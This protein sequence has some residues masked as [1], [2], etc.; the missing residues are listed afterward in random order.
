MQIGVSLG[1]S[2]ASEVTNAWQTP[3]V[4]S[5]GLKLHST[6]AHTSV[7]GLSLEHGNG[8]RDA[9]ALGAD[10][11]MAE[12]CALSERDPV[13][14]TK[15]NAPAA[16]SSCIL[17][18]LFEDGPRAGDID[19]GSGEILLGGSDAALCLSHELCVTLGA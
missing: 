6:R 13:S 19:L 4:V 18:N 5:Q 15:A 11:V 9:D 16:P 14:W 7:Q 3:L 2:A 1:A 17:Y 10:H 12:H 8:K